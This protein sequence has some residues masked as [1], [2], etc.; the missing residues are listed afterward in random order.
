MYTV[1]RAPRSRSCTHLPGR[2]IYCGDDKSDLTDEHIIAFALDGEHAIEAAS[3]PAC[4]ECTCRAEGIC[5]GNMFKAARTRMKMSSRRRRPKMLP[6][7]YRN[8]AD[9]KLRTVDVPVED[10]PTAIFIYAPPLPRMLRAAFPPET[11]GLAHIWAHGDGANL[12]KTRSHTP[13]TQ[14]IMIGEFNEL[15]FARMLAKIG[16]S[17]AVAK[18]HPGGFHP[19]LTDL[20]REK[21]DVFADFIGGDPR[22]S[23]RKAVKHQM[24]LNRIA[25]N[26][27][28]YA[29]VAVQLFAKFGAPVFQVVVGQIESPKKK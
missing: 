9:G 6:V 14:Q 27:A 8:K 13:K 17:F 11:H 18:L 25:I 5:L 15:A 21:N 12:G 24:Q 2:C 23:P 20:I 4:S 16:H 7:T 22:P 19:F 29:V 28:E 10:H 26:G 1:C 3:C